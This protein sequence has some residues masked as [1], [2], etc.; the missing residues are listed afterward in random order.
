MA[1][2]TKMKSMLILLMLFLLGAESKAQEKVLTSGDFSGLETFGYVADKPIDMGDDSWLVSTSQLNSKV[3]YLGCNSSHQSKG[4]LSASSWGDVIPAIKGVVNSFDEKTNHAYA[5]QLNTAYNKVSRI[6]MNWSGSN[7]VFNVYLF[8]DE[9]N[10]LVYKTTAQAAS[11]PTAAGSISC[12]FGTPINATRVVWVAI[13]AANTKTLRITTYEIKGIEEDAPAIAAPSFSV[14]AGTYHENQMVT[15]TAEGGAVIYYTLDGTTPTSTSAVYTQPIAIENTTTLKAIAVKGTDVSHVATAI[16]TIEKLTTVNSIAD[17]KALSTGTKAILMLNN[18]I[19]TAVG[20]NDIFVQD[21]TGGLDLYQSGQ[22][23]K[24]GDVLNGKVSGTYTLYKGVPEIMNGNYSGVTAVAGQGATPMV[25]TIDQLVANPADY[26]YRLLTLEGVTF[27]N[28]KLIQN[29]ATNQLDFYDKFNA[30]GS[31]YIWPPKADITG[32]LT[33]FNVSNLQMTVRT[34]A[35]IVNVS[36]Q[37]VPELT[38]GTTEVTVDWVDETHVYPTLTTDSD[39]ELVYSSSNESVATISDKG[40][41][42]LVGTGETE[43]KVTVSETDQF[44]GAVAVYTLKVINTALVPNAGTA[45]IA[46]F[47]EEY[48]AAGQTLTNGKLNAIRVP[49]VGTVAVASVDDMQSLSWNIT[50]AEA[51]NS[52]E[53]QDA[54]GK[55]LVGTKST[56]NYTLSTTSSNWTK[57]ETDTY[58]YSTDTNRS[59]IYSSSSGFGH[60]AKSNAGNSVYSDFAQPMTLKAGYIRNVTL[61]NFGTVCLSY[62]AKAGEFIGAEFYT[63]VGKRVDEEGNATAVV[64]SEPVTALRAGVPYIFKATAESF[65][66]VY[67]QS[68]GGAQP[69]TN[70]LKA[71]MDGINTEKDPENAVLEG[72]YL[73]SDNQIK[74][75]GKGSSLLANRAY[76]NMNEVPVVDASVKGLIIGMESGTVTGIEGVEA[77]HGMVDVYGVN[78]ALVRQNVKAS[79]AVRALPAGVYIVNGKKIRVK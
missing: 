68:I 36:S 21:A 46:K 42:T 56:T 5:M 47:G 33:V 71:A 27:E 57:D 26:T 2:F 64:L 8:V 34:E 20:S 22:T 23:Y 35:D 49:V 19:V 48:Y 11:G 39:G 55:Y 70:G 43:I 29:N 67:A 51:R 72:M 59:L 37:K 78:G 32:V 62:D 69:Q 44:V 38:W 53:I 1:N 50:I 4:I 6:T 14:E 15:L 45:L 79:E 63:I 75:A 65:V 28:G 40:V 61:D 24:V 12:D 18:A 54:N 30:L 7:A 25:V 41:I 16:Y 3:F 17:L 31:A 77:H 74:K 52:M 66:A 9:G 73:L 10:G 13:P 76:I 58:W 60:Y